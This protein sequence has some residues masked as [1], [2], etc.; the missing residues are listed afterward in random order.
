MQIK[1]KFMAYP[2][3]SS[4]QGTIE[5]LVILGIIIVI[6]LVVVGMLASINDSQD[7]TQKNNKL[8]N[9]IGSGGI[10]V[11]EST[12]DIEGDGALSIKNNSGE[13]LTITKISTTNRELTYNRS[14]ANGSTI[15]FSLDDFNTDCPCTNK[16]RVNCQITI[17]YTTSKGVT[18]TAKL[19]INTTCQ[20]DIPK[21]P[22]I[23]TP[24][25]CPTY[26]RLQNKDGNLIIC[27]CND[28][29]NMRLDL[30]E[31]YALGQ[32]INCYE[33]RTWRSGWGF[34]EIG[35]DSSDKFT[36]NFNGNG[37]K[38]SDLYMYTVGTD[39][40][41]FGYVDGSTIQNVGLENYEIAGAGTFIGALVGYL[42][43][44]TIKNNYTIGSST[45]NT[46]VGGLVGAMA[47][48]TITNNYTAGSVTAL[49]HYAGGLLG[50][51]SGGT[52]SNNYTVASVTGTDSKGLI[53][54]S[55][56]GTKTNNYW[57]I[58]LTGF[59]TCYLDSNTG[60]TAT[61]NNEIAYY[62]SN[63]IPF[64]NLNW[65]TNIWVARNNN[66]PIL[67]WQN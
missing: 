36:G 7:I 30:D 14:L 26:A 64:T 3:N 38:I 43:S 13:T 31:N 29:Q 45:G 40:G 67:S 66:H 4:A 47:A 15:T 19:T 35:P 51:N 46:W 27:D 17:T 20:N 56:V 25:L 57:D 60:C 8:K 65:N 37:H 55:S 48:G 16:Q 53:A 28:L 22:T 49:T 34:F 24:L 59:S 52:I 50:T 58:T 61:D 9:M 54:V 21:Q 39:S 18:K 23:E 2:K 62:G 41:L 32:D 6:G 42:K 1:T 44:G 5:Y 11:L 12:L 63:G 33:T 10:S